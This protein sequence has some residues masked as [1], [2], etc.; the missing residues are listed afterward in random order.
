MAAA[1]Y[2]GWAIAKKSYATLFRAPLDAFRAAGIWIIGLSVYPIILSA[3]FGAVPRFAS[4]MTWVW[5][6]YL[7]HM[8]V[9]SLAYAATAVAWHRYVL[10][11]RQPSF[12][13]PLGRATLVYLI[14]LFLLFLIIWVAPFVIIGLTLPVPA[15]SVARTIIP[16]VMA[17]ALFAVTLRF[18]L[19]LPAIAID[20][21]KIGPIDSWRLSRPIWGR[22]VSGATIAF[23]PSV[24]LMWLVTAAWFRLFGNNPVGSLLVTAAGWTIAFAGVMLLATSLS[25]SYQFAV[26]DEKIAD[27]FA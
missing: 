24:L 8:L 27:V 10:Q 4:N 3:I 13:P 25:L 16:M 11:R 7:G 20:D 5:T 1:G 23:F 19:K 9:V 22:L 15:D 26:G 12:L 21:A 14:T 6:Y 17:F 2:S 18:A